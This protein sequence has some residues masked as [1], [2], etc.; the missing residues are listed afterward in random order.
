MILINEPDPR[1]GRDDWPRK[2]GRI[3][4][5]HPDTGDTLSCYSP[6]LLPSYLGG[7]F[8]NPTWSARCQA[9]GAGLRPDL[10]VMAAPLD[11]AGDKVEL[12]RI[13]TEMELAG[14]RNAAANRGTAIH[15]A[16]RRIWRGIEPDMPPECQADVDA[17]R[18][19]VDEWGIELVDDWDERQVIDLELP[20]CGAPDAYVR[21]RKLG[22]G[23]FVIDP[24]T[25]SIK[26]WDHSLQLAVYANSTH[27]LTP[28]LD[29]VPIP[30]QFRTDIGLILHAPWGKGTCDIVALDLVE[31]WRLAKLAVAA[32]NETLNSGRVV[33]KNVEGLAVTPANPPA[34]STGAS[35]GQE[36]APEAS[37]SNT[38]PTAPVLRITERIGDLRRRAKHLTEQGVITPDDARALMAEHN[39]PAL[40]DPDTHTTAT[41]DMWEG[42]IATCELALDAGQRL[43]RIIERLKALPIDLFAHAEQAAK[44]LTPPVPQLIDGNPTSRDLDR[45]EVVLADVELLHAERVTQVTQALSEHDSDTASSLLDWACENADE[46]PGIDR[47]DNLQA[48]RVLAL[49]ETYRHDDLAAALKP[50]GARESVNIARPLAELHQIPVPTKGADIAA[51]RLLAGLVL[52]H[53]KGT[54]NAH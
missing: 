10:A 16:I 27:E 36:D 7:G 39:L 41:V 37:G 47:L 54:N 51:D 49:C 11:I 45:L 12:D 29:V 48:A 33:I 23:I 28:A 44:N 3:Q 21:V 46:A 42:W 14:G 38:P 35:V 52:T 9:K 13:V 25:G 26:P 4:V 50:I 32:H 34:S 1:P 6:S 20:A 2:R 30:F 15:T 31:G 18:R 24:K 8:S 22:E 5:V 40:S 19:T 17:I 53:N 43:P